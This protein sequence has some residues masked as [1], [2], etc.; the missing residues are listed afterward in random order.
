LNLAAD[1]YA[2]VATPRGGPGVGYCSGWVLGG[3]TATIYFSNPAGAATDMDFS[4][5][6]NII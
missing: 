5:M 6:M 2:L 3:N 1:S 4:F